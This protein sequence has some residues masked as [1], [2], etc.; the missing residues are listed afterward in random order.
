MTTKGIGFALALA[1]AGAGARADEVRFKNGDRLTGTVMSMA[2]GKLLFTSVLAG[3]VTLPMGDLETFSTDGPVVIEL[4]DGTRLTQPVEGAEP[5]QFRVKGGGSFD[6]QSFVLARATRINPEPAAW[7]GSLAGG[8]QSQR[9][10][11][12]SDSGHAEFAARRRSDVDRITF[13]ASYAGARETDSKKTPDV[14]TT[15]QRR[16]TAGGQYDYFFTKKLYGYTRMNAEKDGVA[17]LDLRLLTSVGAGWQVW[18]LPQRSLSFETG[19][20]WVSENFSDDTPDDDF[21]ALR[22]A[23]KYDQG[24]TDHLHFFHTGEWFPGLQAGSGQLLKTSTGFRS[25]LSDTLFLEA[26]V[27]FDWDSEPAEDADRQDVVY[28][29]S[30]GWTY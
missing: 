27:R 9:G 3:K 21:F 11:T 25:P 4:D 19:V 16:V 8:A 5:G 12:V 15:T 29:L 10:N 30:V 28:M 22:A 24:L 17:L 26:K 20:S 18:E 23:W 14:S 13:D 2:E 1:L 7:H 6:G